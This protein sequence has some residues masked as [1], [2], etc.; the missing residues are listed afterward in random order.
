MPIDYNHAGRKPQPVT[1]RIVLQ[2]GE[3]VNL[4]RLARQGTNRPVSRSRA[5]QDLRYWIDQY[6]RLT[7]QIQ[8]AK[9]TNADQWRKDHVDTREL[10]NRRA[11][12]AAQMAD[13]G[14]A[15]LDET[16]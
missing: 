15:V 5:R 13:A 10:Y 9:V 14:A 7:A 12:A 4:S 8:A 11:A 2:D 3:P 6:Q 16:P 1:G